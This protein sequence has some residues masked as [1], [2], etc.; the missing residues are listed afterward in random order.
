MYSTFQ[1]YPKTF[2]TFQSVFKHIPLQ[3]GEIYNNCTFFTE[4]SLWKRHLFNSQSVIFYENTKI[5]I[6]KICDVFYKNISALNPSFFEKDCWVL[7]LIKSSKIVNYQRV[8]NY[9]HAEFY[10]HQNYKSSRL[11]KTEGAI[12]YELTLISQSHIYIIQP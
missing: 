7:T 10:H 6:L 2:I 8:K 5:Y 12:N 4:H 9:V 11:T 1:T 3:H